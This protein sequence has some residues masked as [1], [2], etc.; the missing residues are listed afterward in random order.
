M[1]DWELGYWRKLVRLA[2]RRWPVSTLGGWS[3][4]VPE[5]VGDQVRGVN[6]FWRL[7]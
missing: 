7:R 1:E 2:A 3:G 4:V 5:E 6:L